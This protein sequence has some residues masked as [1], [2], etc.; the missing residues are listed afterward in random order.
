MFSHGWMDEGQ[1]Q[2]Q[3]S[4]QPEMG[5]LDQLKKK[6]NLYKKKDLV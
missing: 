1:E 4:H 3:I 6:K 5:R 2:I